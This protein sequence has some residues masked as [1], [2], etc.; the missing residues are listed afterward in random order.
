MLKKLSALALSLALALLLAV[1]AFAGTHNANFAEEVLVLVNAERAKVGLPALKGNNAQLNAAAKKRAEEI[2]TMAKPDHKRPDG[3]SWETIF[4]DFNVGTR[5]VWGENIAWGQ[6]TPEEVVTG[7]DGWMH[8]PSHKANIL[9]DF[10]RYIPPF[11]SDYTHMGVAAYEENGKYYWVQL[12]IND[13]TVPIVY[14]EKET[15]ILGTNPR[16]QGWWA[17]LLF[18]FA[19]GFV[20][21]WF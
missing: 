17:Y 4:N 12:F 6:P 10:S 20:W 5:T 7:P 19:F 21:M 3:K 11:S 16:Y 2:S 14:L 18:F 9:G 1:P 13:G 15:G 8:S